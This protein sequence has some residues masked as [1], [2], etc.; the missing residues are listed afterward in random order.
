M[1]N[2]T[3]QNHANMYAMIRRDERPKIKRWAPG[4]Y[5]NICTG[6]GA[7]FCGDKLAR[8]CADCAYEMKGSGR[9]KP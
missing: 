1:K 4:N 2:N 3:M 7:S 6:C 5:I 9:E 8:Q